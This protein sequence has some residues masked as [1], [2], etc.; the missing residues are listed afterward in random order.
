MLL[1]HFSSLQAAALSS[2]LSSFSSVPAAFVRYFVPLLRPAAALAR[3]CSRFTEFPSQP[4]AS[5][6]SPNVTRTGKQS[7]KKRTPLIPAR[8][9]SPAWLPEFQISAE[10]S[11]ESL[12]W[13]LGLIAVLLVAI[14]I[15]NLFV[16]QVPPAVEGQSQRSTEVK[17]RRLSPSRWMP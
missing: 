1:I 16:Q 7:V 11:M 15:G 9:N 10:A 13:I 8:Q 5:E 4:D 2:A 3:R 12:V 6:M 14:S 17:R